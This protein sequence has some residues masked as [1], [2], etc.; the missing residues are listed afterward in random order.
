MLTTFKTETGSLYEVRDSG[1]DVHEAKRV[2]A[3]AD[4]DYMG[5][6]IGP[7]W[8]LLAAAPEVEAGQRVVLVWAIG[9]D[10]IKTT[11]TSRVVE[12]RVQA[13]G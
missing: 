8:R 1:G 6:R 10:R 9:P 5:T 12:M 7:E 2:E 13:D 3:G 4:S 11:V